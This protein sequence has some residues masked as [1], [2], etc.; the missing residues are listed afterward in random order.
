MG[1]DVL[2]V[3]V[4]E[5]DND[6]RTLLCDLLVASGAKDCVSAASYEELVRREEQVLECGL[7]LLDVN[8]GGGVHSGL[9]AY[10]WLQQHG[11]RGRVVFLTG[12]ARSHP[13]VRQARELTQA[14]VM[15]KP[16]NA[17]DL[18]A[19]VKDPHGAGKP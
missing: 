2:R 3:L 1:D 16:V 8:L 5:D 11:F 7:A 12:H 9:D 4:L 10:H 17:K 19:L 18:M 6:L 15:S 13:L 14:Q